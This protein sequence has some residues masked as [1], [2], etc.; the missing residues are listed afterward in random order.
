MRAFSPSKKRPARQ[1]S[2]S[3]ARSKSAAGE[4]SARHQSQFRIG[5]LTVNRM[6]QT[7][8][9][10]GRAGDAF[11]QEAERISNQ[12]MRFPA[13]PHSSLQTSRADSDHSGQDTAPPIVHDVLRSSGH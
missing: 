13:Q 7:P 10:I 5:S 9:T 2:Q 8:L 11:E 1:E 3:L 12:V 6:A 4:K